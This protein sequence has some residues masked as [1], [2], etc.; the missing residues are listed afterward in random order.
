MV[1]TRIWTA[2][3]LEAMGEEGLKFEIVRG[4]LREVEGMGERHGAIGGRLQGALAIHIFA[5]DLGELLLS[6]TRFV[7]P[8]NPRSTLAPD[9]TY[10]RGD[11]LPP[12][13]LSEGYSRI[14]PDLVVE[15]VSPS[16]TEPEM[17]NRVSIYL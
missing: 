11:R 12:G 6:D 8:G 15:I 9:I 13:D 1:A 14:V 17:R 4:E 7:L 16:N 5:F 3:D 10:I 2:E